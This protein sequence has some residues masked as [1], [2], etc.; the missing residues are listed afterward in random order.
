M[1]LATPPSISLAPFPS[2]ISDDSNISALEALCE[3]E[4]TSPEAPTPPGNPWL[5]T[6]SSDLGCIEPPSRE[7]FAGMHV[8]DGRRDLQTPD[9]SWR[10]SPVD[11]DLSPTTSTVSMMDLESSPLLVPLD[12]SR[13]VLTLF[14]ICLL[15]FYSS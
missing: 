2:Y 10:E 4:E 5:V 6:R 15:R 14:H 7:A 13:L 11:I 8:F 9:L 3:F 12:I 1:A